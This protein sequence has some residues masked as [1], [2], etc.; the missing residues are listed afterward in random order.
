MSL[1]SSRSTSRNTFQTNKVLE[2]KACTS[3]WK[4]HSH[5]DVPA[6][7]L[8]SMLLA[9]HNAPLDK[10]SKKLPADRCPTPTTSHKSRQSARSSAEDS[11]SETQKAAHR[12][13][14]LM[15]IIN[16]AN[17]IL[18]ESRGKNSLPSI[19]SYISK[20]EKES[21]HTSKADKLYNDLKDRKPNA[22]NFV[23]H[24]FRLSGYGDLSKTPN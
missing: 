9:V 4:M 17:K 8:H 19:Q 22:I 11:L 15:S 20:I 2:N 3:Q 16:S 23:K 7:P 6:A 13:T 14:N 24:I 10:I 12:N 18:I 21:G 5:S 1:V